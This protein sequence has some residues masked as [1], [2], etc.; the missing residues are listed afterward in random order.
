M[1][2]AKKHLGQHFLTDFNIAKK[3]ADTLSEEQEYV[4]EIGPGTGVL[5]KFLQEVPK[6][7]LYVAEVDQESVEYLIEHK[8]VEQDYILGDFLELNIEETFAGDFAI[9]GNFPYNISSQIVFKAID[10]RNQV[11]EFAGMFQKEVAERIGAG[12]GSKTYGII[13][14]MTQ[15]YFDVEYLFTVN[16]NVFYPPPKVKSGVI[17]MKRKEQLHLDCNETLFKTIVKTSFGMR[18]KM[19]RK[20]LRGIIQ[21]PELLSQ[22]IFKK[23]PEQL[24]VKEFVGITNLISDKLIEIGSP[25]IPLFKDFKL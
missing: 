23:R 17:R 7:K 22:E 25:K 8:I 6:R 16:E 14:V 20:S 12:P 21:N 9:I 24:S 2:K 19:L 15:A 18:R 5:T 11:A 4:L 1:V 3:I 13:S 10:Y